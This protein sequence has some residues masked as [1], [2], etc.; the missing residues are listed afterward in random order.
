ME[1]NIFIEKSVF[2]Q[3]VSLAEDGILYRKWQV[4]LRKYFFNLDEKTEDDGNLPNKFYDERIKNLRR[5][6][7]VRRNAKSAHELL[8]FITNNLL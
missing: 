7:E 8:E 2:L 5:L 4:D 3:L 6:Q 1:E